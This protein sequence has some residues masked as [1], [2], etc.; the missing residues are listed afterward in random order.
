[1]WLPGCCPLFCPERYNLESRW[2]WS[3]WS[4]TATE[5]GTSKKEK[6]VVGPEFAPAGVMYQS[7]VLW[8]RFMRTW[9]RHP[10][11]FWAEF[12]QYIFT[13]VFIG[14]GEHFHQCCW[15]PLV[16]VFTLSSV[17]C[18][19]LMLH[20]CNVV[21]IAGS[22]VCF[23]WGKFSAHFIGRK[24]AAGVLCSIEES[25]C[26]TCSGKWCLLPEEVFVMQ[27][28]WH[29]DQ[30]RC[31]GLMYLQINDD[32]T[33]VFDRY[34]SQFFALVALI[35]TPAFTAATVWDSER[36]L[37]RWGDYPL[38]WL[39][40]W[41]TM[42]HCWEHWK[43]NRKSDKCALAFEA[44][45][46]TLGKWQRNNSFWNAASGLSFWLIGEKNGEYG[47]IKFGSELWLNP[48]SNASSYLHRLGSNLWAWHH[49]TCQQ[50]QTIVHQTLPAVTP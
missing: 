24:V 9:W 37:L 30:T 40:F 38:W 8:I 11:M 35:F 15:V 19:D 13:G 2:P 20:L 23:E 49:E 47:E 29:W 44:I 3:V 22:N 7:W 28:I 17:A 26:W 39:Y 34:S 4:L 32:L 16:H 6:P 5:N 21:Y 36:L 27:P 14:M 10:M 12:G 46:A 42:V 1:M 33:G 43:G 41:L 18:E 48:W 50:M 25:K 45:C 31:T